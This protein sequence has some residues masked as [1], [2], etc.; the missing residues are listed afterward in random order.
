MTYHIETV[1]VE[2]FPINSKSFLIGF[3]YRNPNS[4]VKWKE[5]FE[6]HIENVLDEQKEM[7]LLGDFNKDLFNPQVKANWDDYMAQFW[8][9]TTCG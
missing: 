6:A 2:M 9:F 7:I 8:T 4:K 3:L 5:D 1:W